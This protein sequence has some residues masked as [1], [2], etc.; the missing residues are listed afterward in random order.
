[1]TNAPLF[2]MLIF[3]VIFLLFY[4]LAVPSLGGEKAARKRI[5]K[6]LN[7][8]RLSEITDEK[9]ISL[10]RQN[11][12]ED[13]SSFE[14]KLELLPIIRRLALLMEQGG[15][16]RVAHRVALFFLMVA[17]IIFIIVWLFFHNILF[18]LCAGI[19]TVAG[20]IAYL[21]KKRTARL[22]KFEEQLPDALE[23]ITRALRAG[24]PFTDALNVV[25]EEMKD[26]IA[27][28]FGE[29][30]VEISYGY[31]TKVALHNLIGRI[32]SV[33]LMAVVTSVLIQRETGGNLA[34]IVDKISNLIRQR[35]KLHRKIRTLSAE[36]RLSGWIL[37]LLPLVLTSII[38]FTSPTY[39]PRMFEHDLG[40][41][42]II[43]AIIFFMVGVFWMSRIIRIKF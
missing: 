12:M 43:A 15:S 13:L 30:Y 31:D 11:F 1:L 42:L 27:A 26:P 34:E 37:G 21:K 40:E 39:L 33:S 36:G 10:A 17:S 2:L 35:F 25:S 6:R 29:T 24:Y 41:K 18:A 7:E 20:F 38:H 3:V 19:A 8:I 22:E 5:S 16:Y 28:E 14:K 23:A 9:D 4:A 32:P